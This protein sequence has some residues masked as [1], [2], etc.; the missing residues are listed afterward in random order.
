MQY[1]SEF[2]SC[3]SDAMQYQV[4]RIAFA[5]IETALIPL[6]PKMKKEKEKK[7]KQAL[8]WF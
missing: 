2:R 1:P 5:V 7:K 8:V 6:F 3:C 4:R